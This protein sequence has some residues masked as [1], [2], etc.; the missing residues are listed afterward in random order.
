MESN[1]STAI[2]VVTYLRELLADVS[3]LNWGFEKTDAEW[4]LAPVDPIALVPDACQRLRISP[5][6]E[7]TSEAIHICV[8]DYYLPDDVLLYVAR[9]VYEDFGLLTEWE[10]ERPVQKST[11]NVSQEGYSRG[12]H[13]HPAG[14]YERSTTPR[15]PQ[16]SRRQF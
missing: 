3:N 16:W 14:P 13:Q 7:D 10:P 6:D 11:L 1:N 2:T 15:N 12:K 5:L 8:A 9:T 4:R